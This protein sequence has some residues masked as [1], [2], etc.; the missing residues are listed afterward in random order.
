MAEQ[1]AGR[2]WTLLALAG[3]WCAIL[4]IGASEASA[5][6]RA[7][8]LAGGTCEMLNRSTC[9]DQLMGTSQAIGTT[10]ETV[11]CPLLCSAAG[12]ECN[13]QCPAGNTCVLPQNGGAVTSALAL[14]L[15]VPEIPLGGA[16][17][18]QPDACAP[19]LACENGVCATAPAP[20]P[21]MSTV[22]LVVAVATLIGLGGLASSRR[23]RHG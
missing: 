8:C 14:C 18:Q 1:K 4:A 15:C 20:A 10:C 7:C 9:E 13:G 21:L 22:G 16:C 6:V 23:R 19:G 2:R 17:D 5:V 11:T 3:A 12:V